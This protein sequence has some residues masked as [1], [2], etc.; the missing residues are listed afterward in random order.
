MPHREV[1]T[2]AGMNDSDASFWQIA[3]YIEVNL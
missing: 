1:R 3:D 2:L